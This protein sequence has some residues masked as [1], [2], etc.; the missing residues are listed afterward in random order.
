MYDGHSINELQNAAI[1]LIFKL[2]KFRNIDFV[3]N[4][5]LSTSYEFYY[6]DVTVTSFI[7]LDMATLP[8]KS[9]HKEQPSAIRFR[10]AKGLSANAIQSEMRPVC[11][12]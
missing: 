11:S 7:T 2:W 10:W 8:L 1:L 9:S 4:L 6:D 5:I 12:V 3:W